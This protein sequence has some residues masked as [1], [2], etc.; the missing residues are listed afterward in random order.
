ME[1]VIVLSIF[2]GLGAIWLLDRA[3]RKNKKSM[4]KPNEINWEKPESR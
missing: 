2:V 1:E 4:H 3:Q